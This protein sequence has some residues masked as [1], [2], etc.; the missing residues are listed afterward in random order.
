VITYQI[1]LPKRQ[2]AEAFV[3][4]MR[5]E[6]FPAVHKGLTRVGKVTDLVLLQAEAVG[7]TTDC[8]S[9]GTSVGLVWPWATSALTMR[10]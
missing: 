1:R 6:Y 8:D 7:R 9:F 3:K 10:Q 2:D 5:E 4:F